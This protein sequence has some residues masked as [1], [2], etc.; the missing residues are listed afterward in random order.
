MWIAELYLY[1]ENSPVMRIL[2]KVGGRKKEGWHL[3]VCKED[4]ELEVWITGMY[5]ATVIYK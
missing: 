3:T 1:Q 4:V 5:Y 2:S